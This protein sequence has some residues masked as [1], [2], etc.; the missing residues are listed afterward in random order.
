[1]HLG[2]PSHHNQSSR[3]LFRH[4]ECMLRGLST[5][6]AVGSCRT[7][8]QTMSTLLKSLLALSFIE[9]E[10]SNTPFLYSAIPLSGLT[11]VFNLSCARYFLFSLSAKMIALSSVA[12]T[13]ISPFSTPGIS[14]TILSLL[15]LSS[16]ICSLIGDL[17][18]SSIGRSPNNWMDGLPSGPSLN[19]NPATK[20]SFWTF[21]REMLSLMAF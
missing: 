18:P 15:F 9:K 4:L 1:M 7:H 19:E 6:L 5:E 17:Y 2:R 10:I 21:A 13:L 3:L 11:S 8:F 14:N 12:S 20:G 16:I